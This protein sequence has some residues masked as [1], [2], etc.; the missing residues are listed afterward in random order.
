MN[1]KHL[2]VLGFVL[3]P[4]TGA[5]VGA[6]TIGGQ[7]AT[8]ISGGVPLAASNGPTVTVYGSVNATLQD[9]APNSN[10]VN[11]TTDAGNATLSSTGGTSAAVYPGTNLTGTWTN[12]TDI[13]AGG[14]ELTIDAADKP[15]VRTVNGTERLSV[16]D[17]I[18]VDDGQPDFR[19]GGTGTGTVT[20]PS[21]WGLPAS[22]GIKAVDADSGVVLDKSTTDSSGAVTFDINL[23][24]HT[25][26]LETDQTGG[27]GGY[28]PQTDQTDGGESVTL[29][30]WLAVG[31]FSTA[32]TGGWLYAGRR[33]TV[34]TL[35]A[36]VGWSW[37]TV[38]G[39]SV[40]LITDTGSRVALKMVSLQYLTVAL[41]LLSFLALI[42]HQFGHYPPDSDGGINTRGAS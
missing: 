16:R 8:P 39:G 12:V 36:G 31:I 5:A 22:T 14:T 30:L 35:L 23:S 19:I 26:S 21:G 10:T 32:M 1:H 24:A 27:G 41:A 7:Q 34:S 37:L 29:R 6:I 9:F 15:A 25:V 4:V 17:T 20:L 33:L 11:L 18:D 38:T 42:M 28:D 2:F 13:S 40:T 3:A